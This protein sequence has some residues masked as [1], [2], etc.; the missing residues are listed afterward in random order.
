M[1]YIG[2]F[3]LCFL[4]HLSIFTYHKAKYAAKTPSELYKVMEILHF[5]AKK[6]VKSPC[7]T[8]KASF[9]KSLIRHQ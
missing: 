3:I 7:C 8:S 9:T 2:L 1:L 4:F 6:I 5:L